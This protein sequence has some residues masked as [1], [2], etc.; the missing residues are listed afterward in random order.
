MSEN[1]RNYYFWNKQAFE[2]S[3]K[4]IVCPQCPYVDP[5]KECKNPDP[6]GCA[7]FRH[8]PELV[9]VAQRMEDPNLRNYT[10]AVQKQITFSCEQTNP[11]G[12]TCNLLD[13]PRCGLDR[14]LPYVLEAVMK[15][16]RT[17]ETGEQWDVLPTRRFLTK[18]M[19]R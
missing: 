10:E 14:L 6:Q 12:N 16:D 19:V 5:G 1:Q 8:L 7:L 11:P 17:L 3:V 2:N 13:S 18:E 9:R 4:E 15:T